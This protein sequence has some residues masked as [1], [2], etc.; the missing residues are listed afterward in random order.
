MISV[1]V[2]CSD[3]PRF[4]FFSP[5]QADYFQLSLRPGSH[6]SVITSLFSNSDITNLKLDGN[7]SFVLM[8]KQQQCCL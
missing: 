2:Q 8:E 5:I 7:L 6:Q 4:K 3:A 1:W